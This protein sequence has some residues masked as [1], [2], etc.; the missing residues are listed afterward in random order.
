MDIMR[1]ALI[2]EA[3]QMPK[4]AECIATEQQKVYIIHNDVVQQQNMLS[5]STFEQ[6]AMTEAQEIAK[7]A[8]YKQKSEQMKGN[9]NPNFGVE[10]SYEHRLNLQKGV[11]LSK[12]AKRMVSDEKILEIR[13]YYGDNK[14]TFEKLGDHFNISRQYATDIARGKVR[15]LEEIQNDELMK[16]ELDKKISGDTKVLR[17]KLTPKESLNVMQYLIDNPTLKSNQKKVLNALSDKIPNLTLDIIKGYQ[18]GRAQLFEPDFPI[19]GKTWQDF[20]AMQDEL[21]AIMVPNI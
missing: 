8:R 2:T 16:T 7:K 3:E 1:E 14:I 5:K 9:G 13:K 17:R 15:T 21:Q 10:R 6:N 12:H 11:A 20:K 19:D 4:Y 18:K